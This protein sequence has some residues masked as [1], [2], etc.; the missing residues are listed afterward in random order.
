MRILARLIRVGVIL[1]ILLVAIVFVLEN[2]QPVE[3]VFMGWSTP[4]TILAIPVVVAFLLGMSIGPLI[5]VISRFRRRPK[6]AGR[7]P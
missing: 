3:L 5:V 4:S 1:A 7:A 6:G 2:R